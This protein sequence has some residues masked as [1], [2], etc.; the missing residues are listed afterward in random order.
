[1][2]MPS[3]VWG[4][5]RTDL[6]NAGK[7]DLNAIS[8]YF[9]GAAPQAGDVIIVTSLTGSGS[10]TTAPTVTASS[11]WVE[12]YTDSFIIYGAYSCVVK[13][14]SKVLTQADVDA[15]TVAAY[16]VSGETAI[17]EVTSGYGVRGA[18]HASLGF[19]GQKLTDGTTNIAF[20]ALLAPAGGL[21]IRSS[22]P[23]TIDTANFPNTFPN[24][25]PAGW[26]RF[27]LDDDN[28]N[29]DNF[30][31]F[32]HPAP[33]PLA[34]ATTG[35]ANSPYVPNFGFTI[36]LSDTAGPPTLSARIVERW[37]FVNGVPSNTPVGTTIADI[38]DQTSGS[39]L[40][41][42]PTT[43]SFLVLEGTE[44]KI[45]SPITRAVGTD[46]QMDLRE[47]L[48]GASNSPFDFHYT[49]YTAAPTYSRFVASSSGTTTPVLPAHQAGDLLVCFLFR[50]GST[51]AP[52]LPAGWTTAATGTG[53]TCSYRLAYKIAT[54]S[55]ES[56]GTA[57]TATSTITSVYRPTE[58]YTLTI[59]GTSKANAA[60][61]S[62]NY[63]S[64]TF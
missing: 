23:T 47:T 31:A 20:P 25:F 12:H 36:S 11:G 26:T 10:S 50:D 61:S 33:A 48:I 8:P 30:P 2:A 59:G 44:I 64:L 19:A 53:T 49:L 35:Q 58:G 27:G 43:D 34:T 3:A 39:T 37:E 5:V 52:A 46:M 18:S 29:G 55:S 51:T 32:W 60:S 17:V 28:G 9:S 62:I 4:S 24:A 41:L 42:R 14:L 45:G 56:G 22:V 40:S 16:A 63:Q 54:S 7:V 21:V 15:M 38:Y 13:V 6:A 57:T 1:M